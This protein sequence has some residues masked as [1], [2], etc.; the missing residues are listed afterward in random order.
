MTISTMKRKLFFT[1]LFWTLSL[2]AC[3]ASLPPTDVVPLTLISPSPTATQ[4]TPGIEST[5]TNT[6]DSTV[7]CGYQWAYKDLPEINVLLDSALKVINP[8]AKAWATAFGEDC[9]YTDGHATFGAMETD[10]YVQ[11]KVDELSDHESFGN[12]IAQAMPNIV[13]LPHE[14][15]MGPKPGFVEFSFIKSDTEHL[16]VRVPIQ[17]YKDQA[18][19]K[20]GEELF[21]LFYINP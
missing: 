6:P 9:V 14:L 3:T 2:S 7:G 18:T 1:L 16:I 17:M 12:W 15:I 10:F 21:K 4:S 19:G 11:L 13:A 8:N 20:S 5:I